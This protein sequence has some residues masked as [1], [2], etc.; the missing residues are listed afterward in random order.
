MYIL[1]LYEPS[2]TGT[3]TFPENV[4]N[5]LLSKSL[6]LTLASVPSYSFILGEML[7]VGL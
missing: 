6:S 7:L 2:L 4:T 5:R 1:T 3:V